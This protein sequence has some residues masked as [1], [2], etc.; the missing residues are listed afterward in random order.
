MSHEE[1]I[2]EV[3]R[4]IQICMVVAAAEFMKIVV[5]ISGRIVLAEGSYS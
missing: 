4:A 1:C 5:L 3:A 2:L